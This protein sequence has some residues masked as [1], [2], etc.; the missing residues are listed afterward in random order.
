M[1]QVY[2]KLMKSDLTERIMKDRNALQMITLIAYRA[3]RKSGKNRGGATQYQAFIGRSDFPEM[4]ENAYRATKAR[5]V[6]HRVATFQGTGLGT[7][8]TLLNSEVWDINPEGEQ[9]GEQQ[10]GVTSTTPNNNKQSRT[11]I[12]A[13][14]KATTFSLTGC[15]NKTL[16]DDDY[17]NLSMEELLE[18]NDPLSMIKT[19]EDIW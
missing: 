16:T 19:Q 12:T 3:N 17:E 6:R 8:A 1:I 10:G 7:I 9:Q 11:K 14:D 13:S 2:L 15:T 5:V 4:S 18:G